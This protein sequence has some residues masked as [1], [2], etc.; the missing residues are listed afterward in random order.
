MDKFLPKDALWLL[1]II[2]LVFL[3]DLIIPGFTFNTYG[4]RPREMT[5]LPGVFVSPFLHGNLGH[6]LSN[7]ISLLGTAMLVRLAVGTKLMRSI[8]FI[9][10]VGSGAGTWLFGSAGIVVGA[11][12]M[13]YAL[14]G[15]LFAQAVFNPSLRSWLSAVLSLVFFGGALL[16]F[17][18]FMPHISWAGH[19]WGFVTGV[20]TAYLFRPTKK[21]TL[22]DGLTK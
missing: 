6:I 4:I 9:G 15:F 8:M 1:G 12:G 18:N 7:S 5:G 16:S 21:A 17:F 11:S 14:I 13:I 22:R 2:W 3:L 19:F 10:V 20:G